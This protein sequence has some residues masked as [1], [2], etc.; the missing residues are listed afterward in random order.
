M[1]DLLYYLLIIINV[2]LW[3]RL[4]LRNRVGV[5]VTIHSI[6]FVFFLSVPGYLQY[7][8]RVYPWVGRSFVNNDSLVSVLVLLIIY[9]SSFWFAYCTGNKNKNKFNAIKRWQIGGAPVL[10]LDNSYS[11]HGIFG[12]TSHRMP[13]SA[14]N[15]P[16]VV[17]EK[18]AF[19]SNYSRLKIIFIT[20]IFV[21]P[22]IVLIGKIGLPNF[23]TSRDTVGKLVYDESNSISMLYAFGKFSIYGALIF[24]LGIFF[25]NK[26]K[27]IKNNLYFISCLFFVSLMNFIVN[28]P[29]SSPRFHFLG[30]IVGILIVAGIFFK[31]ISNLLL[32]SLS[33]WFLYFIFPNIKQFDSTSKGGALINYLTT[34]VDF[35]SVIQMVNIYEYVEKGAY[36]FGMNI[37]GGFSFF[38]PR[39][40]WNNKPMSLGVLSSESAGYFYTNLSAP[41]PGELFYIFG[42]FSVI[43]GSYLSGRIIR[44]IDTILSV[45]SDPTS[46]SFG[47]SA[48]FSG[49]LF[50]VMRG[51]FG[52]VFPQIAVSLV[53][54]ILFALF[55]LGKKF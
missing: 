4:Y 17:K 45:D 32:F 1:I 31:K 10:T 14:K 3:V 23:F 19:L 50:I 35:D 27:S 29:I 8:Y 15:L 36:S 34:G 22:V 41:W 6:F 48:I 53:T 24:L 49:F 39:I 28:S 40:L 5:A 9:S 55:V 44:K 11:Y 51:S 21:I 18:V 12:A 52:A 47:V 54:Y 46:L 30:M 37:V 7:Y 25:R 42:F 2:S 38:V 26:K 43:V 13:Q 20:F 16:T 33:P